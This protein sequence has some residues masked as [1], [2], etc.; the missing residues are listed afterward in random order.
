MITKVKQLIAIDKIQRF[1]Y[2]LGIVL[3]TVVWWYDDLS[4]NPDK[5]LDWE[6][7]IPSSVLLLQA[8]INNRLVW[9]FLFCLFA[10][11]SILIIILM[12][13]EF[14]GANETIV[15]TELGLMLVIVVIINWILYYMKPTT[16]YTL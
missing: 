11:Y 15:Q 13:P 16:T 12:I 7:A 8:I 6:W 10:L 1:C 4:E 2:L 5:S 3:F 9:K 14:F